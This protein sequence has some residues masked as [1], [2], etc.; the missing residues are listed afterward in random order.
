MQYDAALRCVTRMTAVRACTGNKVILQSQTHQKRDTRHLSSKL[1][2]H[3]I[4]IAQDISCAQAGMQP[5]ILSAGR[6]RSALTLT[7]NKS[8][9]LSRHSALH[10][11]TLTQRTVLTQP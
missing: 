4:F 11:Y 8:T 1:R 5:M 9:A 2:W 6:A 7:K 3:S 10:A